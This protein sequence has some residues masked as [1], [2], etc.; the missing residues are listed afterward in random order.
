MAII[1]RPQK[2]RAEL[3]RDTGVKDTRLTHFIE[4]IDKVRKGLGK[5]EGDCAVREYLKSMP[6]DP[7]SPI[8]R[9]KGLE[10]HQDTPVEVLHVVLLGI[11]KYFWRDAMN[12]L[13]DDAKRMARY[14]LSSLTVDGLHP[15]ITKVS[16][17]TFTKYA[18]SLVGRDFR[19]VAQLAIFVLYDLL[20]KERIA[21]WAALAKLVPL[22]WMP[23]IHDLSAYLVCLSVINMHVP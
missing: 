11:V 3:R 5:V 18:G 6:S 17:T 16:G 20:D 10:P 22:I 7:F 14:R 8:W 9:F 12:Q 13:T 19:V 2:E 15:D 4:E 21:A 23:E 1:G